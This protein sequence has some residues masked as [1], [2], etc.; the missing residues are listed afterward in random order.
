M[1]LMAVLAACC[2][3]S[4]FHHGTVE[5]TLNLS[6]GYRSGDTVF[7][8][9]DHHRYR[10]GR[11]FWFVLPFNVGSRTQSHRT[12]L[13]SLNTRTRALKLEA[14]LAEPAEPTCAVSFAKWALKDGVLFFSYD[15][16]NRLG[17]GGRTVRALY[18]RDMATGAVERIADAGQHEASLFAGYRSPWT[19]NPGVIEIS[20]YKALLPDGVWDGPVPPR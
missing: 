2:W 6:Q 9:A 11:T 17:P 1:P 18:R 13:Y 5:T 10:R 3:A 4:P 14:V 16:S 12:A 8:L 15:P 7:F 20:D 19:A